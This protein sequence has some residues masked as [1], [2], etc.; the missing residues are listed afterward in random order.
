MQENWIGK[1]V[2]VRFAFSHDVKDATEKLVQDGKLF[3]YQGNVNRSNFQNN[4]GS[5][6]LI[7]PSGAAETLFGN[8]SIPDLPNRLRHQSKIGNR[9]SKFRAKP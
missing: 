1:S 9:K 3:V 6:G 4:A 8:D 5:L 7:D 2:G